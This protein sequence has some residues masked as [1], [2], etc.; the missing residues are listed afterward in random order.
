MGVVKREIKRIFARGVLTSGLFLI[1]C[2]VSQIALAQNVTVPRTRP[3]A[4]VDGAGV[5]RI[6]YQGSDWHLHETWYSKGWHD[7]TAQSTVS[8]MAS[9]TSPAAIIING[10]PTV[11]YVSDDWM[12]HQSYLDNSSTWRDSA[13]W[14][15]GP[16]SPAAVVDKTGIVHVFFENANGGLAKASLDTT[17]GSWQF[18]N[19]LYADSSVVKPK[20][21][22][23]AIMENSTNQVSVFYKGTD[24]NLNQTWGWNGVWKNLSLGYPMNGNP[25]AVVSNT[26]I[27]SIFHQGGGSDNSLHQA[28]Y[29]NKWQDYPVG[30]QYTQATGSP[31]TIVDKS[32]LVRVYF[33][34]S[35]GTLWEAYS[36]DASGVYGY[37]FDSMGVAST[38][39]PGVAVE[40]SGQLSVFY[41]GSDGNL[42]Q[43]YCWYGWHDAYLGY[44]V[45]R[46]SDVTPPPPSAAPGGPTWLINNGAYA[47]IQKLGSQAADLAS[48]YFNNTKTY[49][50]VSGS[51]KLSTI[52]AQ[53]RPTLT[54]TSYSDLQNAFL[55]GN[56]PSYIDAIIYD[57]ENWSFTPVVEQQNPALYYQ[58][59]A[60]LIHQHNLRFIATPAIN[61]IQAIEPGYEDP[62]G[63]YQKFI[64]LGIA[65]AVAQYADIY[66]IQVQG[67]ETDLSLSANFVSQASAQA[68]AANPNVTVL[69]GLSTNPMGQSVTSDQLFQLVHATLG[70]VQ[71]YWLNIPGQSPYC[72]S[73]GTPQ[74]QVAQGLL[75]LMAVP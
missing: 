19:F 29:Q 60:E 48:Q 69:A 65:G 55:A 61:L 43:H 11:Y 16:V 49:F 33:L 12:L 66:E 31:V 50:I 7:R 34:G 37:N 5:V 21:D 39:D 63:K 58:K 30:T 40:N 42:D 74:P 2:D 14:S 9:G 25:S 23:S 15:V 27:V 17:T 54:F 35:G 59:A 36:T 57:S 6:Y 28:Y 71:G 47:S 18:L 64:D 1:L 24:G 20:S 73:C 10:L 72:P 32:G 13:L 53:S 51:T 56:I 70:T 46:G 67:S 26:G 3:S 22:L 44:P 52:P 62:K 45:K 4:V 68:K 41:R 38:D 75:Q 8:T